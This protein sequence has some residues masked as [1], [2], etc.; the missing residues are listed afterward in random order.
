MN[1][2]HTLRLSELMQNIPGDW[3]LYE[4]LALGIDNYGLKI[5][6]RKPSP[7]RRGAVFRGSLLSARFNPTTVLQVVERDSP[8]IRHD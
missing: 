7:K 6:N 5:R 2:H 1:K 4:T 3:L 8:C